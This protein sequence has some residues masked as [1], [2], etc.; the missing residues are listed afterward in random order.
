MEELQHNNNEYGSTLI[1]VLIA[2]GVAVG[3]ISAITIAVITGLSNTQS[4]KN[5]NLATQ[6]AEQGMEVVQT[7]RNSDWTTFSSLSN[8]YCLPRN[9]TTLTPRIGTSC[10]QNVDIFVREVT[11]TAASSDCTPPTLTPPLAPTPTPV[12]ISANA[13]KVTVT[14]SWSDNNCTDR[15]NLFCHQTKLISCLSDYTLIPTP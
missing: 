2:L 12:A 11:L 5:Q 9:S 8:V 10:G 14:V 13:T 1:E 3:I 15:D 7:L 6:Y 4:A